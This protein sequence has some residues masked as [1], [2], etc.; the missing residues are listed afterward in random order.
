MNVQLISQDDDL[1]KLCQEILSELPRRDWHLFG[2]TLENRAANTDLYI[3]DFRPDVELPSAFE[4][5]LSRHLFLVHRKDV[6]RFHERLGRTEA[7][8]LLKPVTRA[9]L[10]AF[11]GLAVSAH[12]DRVTTAS[13]L[14]ADR[15]E[16][17]QCL[18]QT[19]LKLQE[20]DQDRTNFLARA[21]HDF[22]APLTAVSG[23]SGL[24]LSEAL[25]AAQRRSKR[26][27]QPDAAQRHAAFPDGVSHVPAKRWTPCEK[28]AGSA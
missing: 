18:I 27:P 1:R 23:Y 19:N 17:L 14:R 15:D 5:G 13:R 16:I 25:G 11:L 6:A 26:S 28:A 20:Y 9:T 7:N 10:S 22:R 24:L 3:W 12:E 21:V 4:E 8:V 2:P